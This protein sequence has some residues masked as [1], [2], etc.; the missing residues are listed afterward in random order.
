MHPGDIIRMHCSCSACSQ[1]P[2]FCHPTNSLRQCPLVLIARQA[3]ASAIRERVGP[4]EHPARE[5]GS[6]LPGCAGAVEPGLQ[7]P[8]LGFGRAQGMP[9]IPTTCFTTSR[10]LAAHNDKAMR[11]IRFQAYADQAAAGVGEG[12]AVDVTEH[13]QPC[14]GT[15]VPLQTPRSHCTLPTASR[16]G[17]RQMTGGS[18]R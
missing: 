3:I 8:G 1:Y 2:F 13:P 5:F 11:R 15:N 18:G 14:H 7:A 6:S 17:K 16:N 12:R 4:P 9:I 10:K